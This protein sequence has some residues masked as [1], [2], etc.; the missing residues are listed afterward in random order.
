MDAA[1]A[2]AKLGETVTIVDVIREVVTKPSG[3]V[4]LNFGAMYPNEILTAVIM[5]E[6]LPRFPGIKKWN[7][8]QVRLSGEITEYKGHRRIILRNRGQIQLAN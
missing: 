6:T 5:A 4:F 1:E 7:G 3:T 8:H 2:A